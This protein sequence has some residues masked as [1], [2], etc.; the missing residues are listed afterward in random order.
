MGSRITMTLQIPEAIRRQLAEA[1]RA[2]A[3]LEACGL[4]AGAEGRVEKCYPMTNADASA[5]HFSIQLAEQFA[6]V[7][8]MRAHSW[9][10]LAIWHSHPA[11][12]ARMS[13]EDLR[14][15]YTPGVVHLIVSLAA[16]EAESLRGFVLEN[17][18]AREVEVMGVGG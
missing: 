4:L 12:P 2:A 17:G 18:A 11:T 10:M 15:A 1:A 16:P 5:E 7:K 8:D 3:P 6:A 13:A 14:L 9:Q